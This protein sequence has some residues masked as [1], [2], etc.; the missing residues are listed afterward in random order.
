M[1]TLGDLTYPMILRYV[2]DIVTVSED[3]IRQAIAQA[4]VDAHLVLEPAGAVALAAAVL[5]AGQAAAD[6]PV[7]AMASGGNITR[8]A[9]RMALANTG[10]A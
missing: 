1:Q 8:N 4:A 3:Q 7:I 2:D 9:L 6:R 5:Y 10:Q